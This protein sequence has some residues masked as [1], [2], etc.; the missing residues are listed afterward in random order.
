VHFPR[1]DIVVKIGAERS[2]KLGQHVDVQ[3]FQDVTLHKLAD[4]G[5]DTRREA[6]GREVY[7]VRS[8]HEPGAGRL[9]RV[10]SCAAE[11]GQNAGRERREENFRVAAAPWGGSDFHDGGGTSATRRI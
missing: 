3:D 8:A 4:A 9:R 6:T 5:D 1:S 11:E 2:Q 7:G 10:A